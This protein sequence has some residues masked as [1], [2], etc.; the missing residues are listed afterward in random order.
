MWG[1]LKF[2]YVHMH[3]NVKMRYVE[4]IPGRGLRGK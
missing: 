1:K 2:Y 4:I 3:V